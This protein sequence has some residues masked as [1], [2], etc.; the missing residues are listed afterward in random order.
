MCKQCK[1]CVKC[2]VDV[3]LC[4]SCHDECPIYISDR[5]YHDQ[6]IKE[7]ARESEFL[8]GLVDSIARCN[9]RRNYR[10]ATAGGTFD[11]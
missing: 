5:T 11:E 3:N 2:W 9:M 8:G 4:T 1:E 7:R 10:H 6:I